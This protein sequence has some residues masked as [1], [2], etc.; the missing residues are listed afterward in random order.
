V[1]GTA[2]SASDAIDGND[3]A[4][5]TVGATIRAEAKPGKAAALLGAVGTSVEAGRLAPARRGTSWAGTCPDHKAPTT[6]TQQTFRIP[7]S[8]VS[9]H[10]MGSKQGKGSRHGH[11]VWNT[12]QRM[13]RW[14]VRPKEKATWPSQAAP[15]RP[16]LFHDAFVSVKPHQEGISR[17]IQLHVAV[18]RMSR[19]EGQQKKAYTPQEVG[20]QPYQ[21][22]LPAKRTRSHTMMNKVIL[23]GRMGKDPDLKTFANGGALANLRVITN[24]VWKDRQ[25]GAFR[26]RADGHNIVV[27][28]AEAAKRLANVLKK[29]DLV[30][31][32]GTLENRQWT[33]QEGRTRWVTEIVVRGGGG[34]VK[35]LGGHRQGIPTGGQ[36]M[37]D[38]AGDLALQDAP[39]APTE[40]VTGTPPSEDIDFFDSGFDDGFG[41]P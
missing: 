39:E 29:G 12:Q 3:G 4:V 24:Q 35:R 2:A 20:T 36:T 34:T 11:L 15:M 37:A 19:P 17:S 40:E 13:T 22:H 10:Q 8:L 9:I 26:E 16:R 18:S 5:T 41:T 14:C 27:H 23:I 28:Q 33:D 21:H 6:A 30:Q 38:T 31:I 32:E 7:I 25:T 1:A